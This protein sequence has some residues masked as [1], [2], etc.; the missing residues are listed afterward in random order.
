[1]INGVFIP[2]AL[3]IFALVFLILAILYVIIL[4]VKLFARSAAAEQVERWLVMFAKSINEKKFNKDGGK[5]D[6]EK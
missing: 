5:S 1:M 2:T 6:E 3:E 4:L